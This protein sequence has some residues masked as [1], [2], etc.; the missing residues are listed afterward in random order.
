[1]LETDYFYYEIGY[2]DYV[3]KV[4]SKDREDVFNYITAQIQNGIIPSAEDIANEITCMPNTLAAFE[5]DDI[6]RN[7][8]IDRI[9]K[10]NIVLLVE[11]II[12]K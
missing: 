7:I 5:S 6:V 3:F 4:I 10:K 12:W 11:K 9:L 1:M 8:K 2:Y